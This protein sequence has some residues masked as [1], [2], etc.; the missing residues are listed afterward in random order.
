MGC[1][2]VCQPMHLEP[3]QEGQSERIPPAPCLVR[4]RRLLL[5]L[6]L[7]MARELSS[8]VCME[9]G[10]MNVAVLPCA[11]NNWIVLRDAVLVEESG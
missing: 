9:L 2:S 6:L 10:D 3:A 4:T 5:P 1:Q 7:S 8:A 11:K